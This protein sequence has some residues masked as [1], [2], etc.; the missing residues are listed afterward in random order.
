MNK[1]L[2]DYKG[3]ASLISKEIF[4][5]LQLTRYITKTNQGESPILKPLKGL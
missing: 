4:L 1:V 3:F 5:G 2:Q